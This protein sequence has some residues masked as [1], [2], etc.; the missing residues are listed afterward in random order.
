MNGKNGLPFIVDLVRNGKMDKIDVC[1]TDP[2]FNLD[3]EQNLNEGER[4]SDK[5]HKVFYRDD[6]TEDEYREW[7]RSWFVMLEELCDIVLIYCGNVNKHIWYDIKKPLDELIYFIPFNRIVTPTAW[8]GRYRTILIYGTKKT[9]A[10]RKFDTNVLVQK[11]KEGKQ[12]WT[13]PCP[14]D[15]KMTVEVLQQIRARNVIDPFAGS[16]TVPQA[17]LALKIPFIAYELDREYEGD[18][19]RRKSDVTPIKKNTSID[20]F[21]K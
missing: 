21:F 19:N 3:L 16:G 2:P 18:W 15:Y 12:K 7:C 6:M 9:F 13:H 4:I 10:T 8:V 11:K 1:L 17:A 20:S 14:L 5:E